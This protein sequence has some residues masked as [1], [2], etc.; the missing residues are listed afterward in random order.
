MTL[1]RLLAT[2]HRR[3]AN[4]HTTGGVTVVARQLGITKQS[5]DNYLKGRCVPTAETRK[6]IVAAL[7]G[8]G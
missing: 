2:L 8:K 6:Q 1:P 3:V 4:A 7:Q 5:L